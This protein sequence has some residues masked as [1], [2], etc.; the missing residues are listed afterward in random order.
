MKR[1]WIAA[2]C[3]VALSVATCVPVFAASPKTST[4]MQTPVSVPTSVVAAK[5]YTLT[6]AE[7]ALVATTPEQAVALAAGITFDVN[8]KLDAGVLFGSLP[9]DPA[10]IAMAKA[11]LLKDV[12]LQKKLEKAGVLGILLKSGV[13]GFSNGK[14]GSYTVTLAAEGLVPGEKVSILVYTPDSVK[15]KVYKATWKNGKLSAKL[16]MPCNYSIIK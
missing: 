12:E 13:L 14:T 15:P 7:Q 3:A 1:K 10:M 11:D 2:V 4:V 5:H 16:P 9:A 8:A 6:P